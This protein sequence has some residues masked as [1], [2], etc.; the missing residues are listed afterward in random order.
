VATAAAADV[1]WRL[2]GLVVV[3]HGSILN[4]TP[5]C[6]STGVT[7]L[8]RRCDATPQAEAAVRLVCCHEL[9]HIGVL[10]VDTCGM[11]QCGAGDVGIACV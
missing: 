8:I 5:L 2:R 1:G 9:G 3:G 6:G 10:V 4:V 7:A 11:Q